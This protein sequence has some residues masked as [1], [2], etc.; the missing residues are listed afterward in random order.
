M[1]MAK[2]IRGP[3]WSVDHLPGSSVN[4]GDVIVLNNL[5]LICNVDD[6]INAQ[7][8]IRQTSVYMGGIYQV[9]A[10]AAYGNGTYVYWDTV[11]QQVST[12]VTAAAYAF[13]WIVSGPQGLLS[14][15]GPTGAGSACYVEHAPLAAV[16]TSGNPPLVNPRNMIDG[17][18]MTTNP[19]QRGTSQTA[20]ITSSVTY[21]PDRFAFKGSGGSAINWSIN[22]D[23][24]VA[25]FSKSLKFQRKSANADVNPLNMCQVLE[26]S[27]SVRAQG[28]TVTFSFWAKKGAN[29]SGGALTVQVESGL[30]TDQAASNLIAGTWTTQTHVINTT[31]VL[32]ATMT[33]YQFTAAVPAGCT[34]LGIILQW[35]PTGTAGADDSITLNGLQLEVASGATAYEHR[36]VEIELA[37]CQRYFYQI[38]EPASGVI[39]AAGHNSASNTQTYVMALPTPMRAAPTVTVT[40]GSFK[41][42]SSTAGIVAATG[43]T[44]SGTHTTTMIGLTS[45]GTGTA[46]QGST[47]Q[48]G[49]GVGLIA[50]SADY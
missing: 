46:G 16:Q 34:Q 49:G 41:A 43:L 37:L 22:A 13:G 32:T 48:G 39:V 45:T 5:T 23:T 40:V 6:P 2:Y 24:S 3:R 21:G 50:V 44:A 47:L 15:G 12:V 19:A 36:D 31:Q 7:D 35:T 17:G 11:K 14:D 29:Y 25:G 10:D 38:G 9:N 26:T 8:G 30:G 20:D 33:R 42:N 28:Q 27:D 4:A 18:D 1:T